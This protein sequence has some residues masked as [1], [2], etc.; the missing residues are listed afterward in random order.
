L[1]QNTVYN[2]ASWI[3]EL[4]CLN[5]WGSAAHNAELFTQSQIN[6]RKF[7][8]LEDEDLKLIKIPKLGHRIV[9]LM[10]V[11]YVVL[12]E[13]QLFSHMS[14]GAS[15]RGLVSGNCEYRE[16]VAG[17]YQQKNPSRSSQQLQPRGPLMVETPPLIE[18]K[19]EMCLAPIPED[20]SITC[21]HVRS[22]LVRPSPV[23][24]AKL[25]LKF[26]NTSKRSIDTLYSHF[27]KLGYEVKI[28]SVDETQYDIVFSDVPSAEDAF[29][30]RLELC[31]TIEKAMSEEKKHCAPKSSQSKTQAGR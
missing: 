23:S 20:G 14:D 28:Q 30:K 26:Q 31:Y 21:S 29:N 12:S 27:D 15:Y 25:V 5:N 4:A 7:V 1:E 10:A 2:I 8:P 9:I 11:K 16:H 24:D 17:R 13:K 6:G 19:E 3:Y 18:S 22:M